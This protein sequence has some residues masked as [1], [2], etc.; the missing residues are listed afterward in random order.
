M[1]SQQ[2]RIELVTRPVGDQSLEHIM[3]FTRL[4]ALGSLFSMLNQAVRNVLHYN[5]T[6]SD[7][8][9]MIEHLEK[10]ISKA[11]VHAV[12]WSFAGDAKMKNRNEMSDFIR[13]RVKVFS[14][15]PVS[16][17]KSRGTPAQ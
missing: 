5:H 6:H 7:F 2:N 13:Y 12:L 16:L 8:P 15:L 17:Q 11:L 10:Y 9:M 14:Q 3:D 1:K 4:R